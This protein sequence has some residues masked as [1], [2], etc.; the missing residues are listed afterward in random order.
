MSVDAP[1][2][3]RYHI[4]PGTGVRN[5]YELLGVLGTQPQKQY[6]LLTTD[7]SCLDPRPNLFLQKYMFPLRDLWKRCPCFVFQRKEVT[8]S[9]CVCCSAGEEVK[10]V[11]G[12]IWVRQVLEG[13]SIHS[14]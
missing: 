4:P 11:A 6:I 8:N 3:Q 13:P 9:G 5:S 10:V 1:R 12:Y 7:P 2:D 14:C